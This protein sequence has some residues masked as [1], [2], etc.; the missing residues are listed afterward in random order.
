VGLSQKHAF[1]G[2]REG[3]KRDA[4]EAALNML[5]QYLCVKTKD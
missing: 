3:N 1:L 4:A 5:K 2:N